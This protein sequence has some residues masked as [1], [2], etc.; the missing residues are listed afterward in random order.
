[1]KV[2]ELGEF[3][4]IELLA[5]IVD[6]TRNPG[7]ISWQRLLIGIGDDEIAPSNWLLQIA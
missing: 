7:Y 2:S 4:L 5:D 3:G 1:M 6:R